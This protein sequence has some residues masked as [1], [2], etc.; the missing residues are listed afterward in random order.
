MCWQKD[1]VLPH[2]KLFLVK[3]DQ[4]SIVLENDGVDTTS[5]TVKVQT[6]TTNAASEVYS[7]A[8]D[9]LNVTSTSKVFYLEERTD[10]YYQINFG[11][12]VLG[13]QL[14]VGNI[15]IVD[16]IA[17]NGAAVM[18]S[19]IFLAHQFNWIGGKHIWF[20]KVCFC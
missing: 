3:I 20:Y 9:T 15:V 13:K 1:C 7:L 14:E 11:D 16:Y 12:G 6:S 18:E 19:T 8:E 2:Q 17:C 4:L 10:G 5:I